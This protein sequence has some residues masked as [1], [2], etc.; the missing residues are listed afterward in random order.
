MIKK[1]YGIN[2]NN[3]KVEL[4]FNRLLMITDNDSYLEIDTNT[5]HHPEQPDF[6]INVETGPVK[7]IPNNPGKFEAVEGHRYLCVL[8]GAN[9]LLF[10]KVKRKQKAV[11]K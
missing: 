4:N 5:H 9:N 2:E 7:E 10:I 3:E 11:G 6:A 1:I 8:P